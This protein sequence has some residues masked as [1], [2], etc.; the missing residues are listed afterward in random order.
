MIVDVYHR[1][2]HDSSFNKLIGDDY[3]VMEYKC[4]IETNLFQVMSEMHIITYVISG[5][6]DW[7]TPDQTCTV[8][9]GEAMFIRKGVYTVRQYFEVDHCILTF[10]ISDEFIRNFMHEH[11]TVSQGMGLPIGDQ[12]FKLEVN[13]SL[14][15][16]FV[17][18][19]NYM[20]MT[21]DIPR[22]LV[23]IKFN[24]LLFN[25]VLNPNHERLT[26]FLFSVNRT[27]ATALDHV[28]LKNFQHD[29]SVN[30]FARLCG[31]SLSTF[32]R[33]FIDHYKVPPAK[34]LRNKRLEYAA[35][36]LLASDLDVKE[37]VYESGFNN[38]SHFNRVFKEKYGLAP[39]QYRVNKTKV[40]QDN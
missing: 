36:L 20:K 22:S 40:N 12:L 5:K 9:E 34:W 11:K 19:Y 28:M 14:K 30:D 21:P 8:S 35:S 15:V 17:S 32:K 33:D 31:S 2:R 24:E 38:S 27:R 6:K 25:I 26:Q 1:F 7:I 3:M 18:V 39:N 13:E 10:F 16:L 23:E 4:P 37:V 29:L